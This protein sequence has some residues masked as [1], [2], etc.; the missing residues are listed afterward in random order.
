MRGKATTEMLLRSLCLTTMVREYGDLARKAEK[1]D[2]GHERYLHNLCEVELSERAGRRVKRRLKQAGLPD[3]KTMET[4]DQ[5]LLPLK[6]RCQI[7]RL[8][9]GDFVGWLF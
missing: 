1:D 7:P 6:V 9:E 8:L 5:R 3:S 2:W 4:L